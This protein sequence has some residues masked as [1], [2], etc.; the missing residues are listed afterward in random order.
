MRLSLATVLAAAAITLQAS[1]PAP[2]RPVLSAYTVHAGS[3]HI[4]ETYLS[5]LKYSGQAFGLGYERM[6]AMKFN[7]E[8]W[9]QTLD[10]GLD[11]ARTLNP[12]RNATTWQLMLEGAWSMTHRWKLHGGWSLYAGGTPTCSS[13]CSTTG[14]TAT[15]RQRQKRHSP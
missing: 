4:A 11:F 13:A 12:A 6:Q 5:P 14:A 8:H 10:L 2:V 15:T 1:E 9:V 7:P 3:A